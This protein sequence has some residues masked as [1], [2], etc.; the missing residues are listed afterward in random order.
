MAGNI[1]H[2]S[3]TSIPA[4]TAFI[5]FGTLL[6]YHF[7]PVMSLRW[8]SLVIMLESISLLSICA[9]IIANDLLWTVLGIW[10]Y[11][12][13][14]TPLYLIVVKAQ[15][16]MDVE[17]NCDRI[18]FSN[19]FKMCSNAVFSDYRI[20]LT[21]KIPLVTQALV[22]GSILYQ[23]FAADWIIHALAGFGIGAIALKAYETAVNNYGY[24]PLVSYFHLGKLRISEVEKRTGSI[25]FTLFSVI[26]VASI[27]E[28]FE[29]AIYLTSPINAFRI[30]IEPSWNIIGDMVS[31]IAGA[32]AAWYLVKCKLKWL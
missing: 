26:V 15:R 29:R 24:S 22:G 13:V 1:E 10:T 6:I 23:V 27:W 25:G 14:C 12:I 11:V 5:P 3:G 30:E 17:K 16:A 9:N 21:A 20:S 4:S 28:V 19:L 18:S 2:R 7:Y 8:V 31:A 32:I